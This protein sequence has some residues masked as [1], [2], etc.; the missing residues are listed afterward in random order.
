LELYSPKL[1]EKPEVIVL[2][3]IDLDPDR[4]LVKEYTERLPGEKP[5]L[6]VSAVT[7][8]GIAELNELL[9]SLGKGKTYESGRD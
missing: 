4:T 2:N 6:A 7:G 5:I 3:K 1:L 9:W 8:E